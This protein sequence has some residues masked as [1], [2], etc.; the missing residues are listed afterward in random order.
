MAHASVITRG[1]IT[2]K[3]ILIQKDKDATDN[4]LDPL[5]EKN[6]IIKANTTLDLMEMETADKPPGTAFI[7]AKKL[8][9]KSVLYQLST[10]EAAVWLKQNE[11]WRFFMANYDGMSNICNKLYYIITEFAPTI[12]EEGSSYIH[13]KAEED[14]ML[15]TNIIIYLKYIK[16]THLCASN[17]K[18]AHVVFGFNNRHEANLPI[19][20]DMFVK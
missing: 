4:M 10:R 19:E 9:N 5:T 15:S 2:D 14:S 20:D 16:P 13:A 6:L 7:E 18:V 1:D 17:Q 12:F 8:R 11:V 3:Q